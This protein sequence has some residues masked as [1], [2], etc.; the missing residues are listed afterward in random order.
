VSTAGPAI[1]ADRTGETCIRLTGEWS[2]VGAPHPDGG[3]RVRV[4]PS[5]LVGE[6]DEPPA[7][8]PMA[9][10]AG[11]DGDGVWFVPR[12]GFV[13]GTSYTVFVEPASPGASPEGTT[14][15]TTMVYPGRA[16]AGRTS[17]TAIYPSAGAIPYNQLRLYL[18]FSAAMSEGAAAGH[19][20]LLDDASGHE[21]EN[22]LL[23]MEPELWD[24]ERR[25]LTILLDP[26]RLKRGLRPHRLAGYPLQPGGAVRVVVHPDLR[27]AG[28]H[29]LRGQF[30]HRY[31]VGPDVREH[32]TPGRWHLTPPAP[33][34]R[35]PVVVDFDRPLDHGLLGWCL[36]V[37]TGAG[38]PL[39]GSAAAGQE[40]RSWAFIPTS[41]WVSGLYHLMVDPRLEDLA[42]NSVARVFDRDLRLP[43]DDPRPARPVRR[44]FA[45]E[46]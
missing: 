31:Q 46:R 5:E 16:P 1:W 35:Q 13:P 30:E 45:V 10:R 3:P 9:G 44:P 38:R 27:D 12:F 4:Y 24:R 11:I 33:G 36:T 20:H 28:G 18:Q 26:G 21:L 22:A 15:A 43:Q 17:V 34:T 8:P 39:A 25:R 2:G 37:T 23:P 14:S 19:V 42:G 29:R 7:L 32:V 40:E 41:P 6:A